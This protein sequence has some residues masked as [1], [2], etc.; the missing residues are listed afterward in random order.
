MKKTKKTIFNRNLDIYWVITFIVLIIYTTW[1]IY[2][3]VN[4][5]IKIKSIYRD[6]ETKQMENNFLRSEIIRLKIEKNNSVFDLDFDTDNS[7]YKFV[8]SNKSFNNKFYIPKNLEEIWSKFIYDVKGGG[9]L[10]TSE[11]NEALQELWK[12]FYEKFNKKLPIVSAYR[13]YLYQEG[14]KDW[15]CPDNLCAVAW[16]S[17]HQSGLAVDVLEVSTNSA[18]KN[19][20]KLT[21]YYNWFNDYAHTY[22]FTNTYQKWIEVDWYEIEPWHWRYVGITLATYLKENDLTIAEFYNKIK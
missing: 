6:I 12:A 16:F 1:L 22:G 13:S 7:T 3:L 21:S 4:S 17:E 10:V 15:W 11:T 20:S 18:W 9:Q 19:N 5:H 2:F 8:S 14:I